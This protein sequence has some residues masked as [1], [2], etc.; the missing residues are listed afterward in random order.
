MKNSFCLFLCALVFGAGL[1]QGQSAL[2]RSNGAL[3]TNEFRGPE[4]RIP[5]AS[6]KP[7][8]AIVYNPNGRFLAVAGGDNAIRVYEG[9]I[10]AGLMARL[11]QKLTGHTLPVLAIAFIDTNTLVSVSED[12][13]VKTWDVASGKLLHSTA[14]NFGKQ[15]VP[16]IAPKSLPLFAGGTLRQVRLWN[17]QTGELLHS[18]EANDSDVAALAFTPDGK[19]LV[20][21]TVKGVVRVMDVATWKVARAID[22][23]SPVRALAASA[24][25]IVVGYAEGTVA[26]LNFGDQESIPEGKKHSGAINAVAFSPKGDRFASASA[27]K[28]VKVWDTETLKVLC[29]LEGHRGEVVSVAFD[30][31]GTRLASGGADGMVNCWAVLSGTAASDQKAR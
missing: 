17:Y 9:R 10:T 1:V 19:L 27:D 4:F 15:L 30:P 14:V 6:S 12:Q 21:G 8:T 29:T 31:I 22:L 20:I 7:I 3:F 25:H 16:A 18:F 2:E 24:N 26:L 28:M 23:D 13:T 5:A 11:D